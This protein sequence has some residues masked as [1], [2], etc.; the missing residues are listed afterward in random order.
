M[1]GKPNSELWIERDFAPL[2]GR[3]LKTLRLA[4]LSGILS[5][6]QRLVERNI[7]EQTGVSRSSVREA[8]RC[9][10]SEG[11][12]ESRLPKGVFVTVLSKKQALEIYEI[13]AALESEA[14]RHF[15]ERANKSEIEELARTCERC[16]GFVLA[17]PQALIREM[18]NFFAILFAGAQNETAQNLIQPLRARIGHLRT[19]TSLI[20]SSDQ[21]AAAVKH[22]KNVV[23][24]V[25]KRDSDA[26]L[27]LAERTLLTRRRSPPRILTTMDRSMPDGHRFV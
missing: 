9:L 8:M 2:R 15:S 26:A 4:I 10:E 7:C 18:R 25:R 14:A 17:D 11:L 16:A 23:N 21:L 24:A 12:V 20:A 13:R 27:V 1:S 6:G 3:T 22:L 19:V 5:P